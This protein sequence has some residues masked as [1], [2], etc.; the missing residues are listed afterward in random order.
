MRASCPTPTPSRRW[1]CR[2]DYGAYID[3]RVDHP[4]DDLMT[5]LLNAEFDG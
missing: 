4:S 1:Q 5:E 2:P 3:W